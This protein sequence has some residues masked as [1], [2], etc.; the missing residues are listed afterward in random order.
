MTRSKVLQKVHRG[1]H[2]TSA[3]Y[4][5]RVDKYIVY[6]R[7]RSRAIILILECGVNTCYGFKLKNRGRGVHIHV[8]KM[9][10]KDIQTLVCIKIRGNEYTVIEFVFNH[11]SKL[12]LD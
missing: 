8:K 9:M 5:W 3:L 7:D 10:G 6:N 1:L 12:A 2:D 11:N 4:T